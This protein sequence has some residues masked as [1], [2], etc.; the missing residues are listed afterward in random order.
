MFTVLNSKIED[1]YR[2]ALI[3]LIVSIG[4]TVA[5]WW[6][7]V[8]KDPDTFPNPFDGNDEKDKDSD[9]KKQ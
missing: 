1:K 7:L 4:F 2:D 5:K 3:S 8:R 6:Q 9:N